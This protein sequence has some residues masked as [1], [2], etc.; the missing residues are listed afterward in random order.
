MTTFTAPPTPTIA[1]PAHHGPLD[2]FD[3]RYKTNP[4]KKTREKTRDTNLSGPNAWARCLRNALN[5]LSRLLTRT[6]SLGSARCSPSPEVT[7]RSFHPAPPGPRVSPGWT[8]AIFGDLGRYVRRIATGGAQKT[9]VEGVV[10][11][12]TLMVT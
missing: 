5:S 7:H 10:S 3:T 9:G 6:P 8:N 4:A 1:T 2:P 12:A 11:G